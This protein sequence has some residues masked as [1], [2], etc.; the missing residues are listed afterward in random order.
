M[1][2]T[3]RRPRRGKRV[4][5]GSSQDV[6]PNAS[7]GI[8]EPKAAGF[9]VPVSSIVRPCGPGERLLAG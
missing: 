5:V 9:I 8:Q 2:A 7:T 6:T 4:G 1:R 3:E